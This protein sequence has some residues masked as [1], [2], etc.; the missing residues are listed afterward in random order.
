MRLTEMKERGKTRAYRSQQFE[1]LREEHSE[2]K[3]KIKIIK[4]NNETN[5][6]DIENNE[7]EQIKAILLK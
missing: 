4:P 2:Y 3:T 1:E 6:L 7:F 5:W